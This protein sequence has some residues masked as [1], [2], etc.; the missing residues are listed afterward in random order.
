MPADGCD[1][2]TYTFGM[3]RGVLG[4]LVGGGPAP[5]INGVIEAATIEAINN[6]FDVIGIYDGFQW[7]ASEAFDPDA[8]TTPLTIARV[9][10]IHFDGGSILR[11][12]RTSLLDE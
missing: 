8:H 9:S 11:T 4:I 7:L 1:T 2:R 5:G 12:A 10:R 6:R 3:K